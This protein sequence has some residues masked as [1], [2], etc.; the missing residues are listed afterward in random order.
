MTKISVNDLPKVAFAFVRQQIIPKV[1]DGPVQ[2][3]LGLGNNYLISLMTEKCFN[4]L[5][6]K[7]LPV[8]KTLGIIDDK[9][10][11]DLDLLHKSAVS[12]IEDCTDQRVKIPL[13]DN[14]AF[15]LDKSDI[16]TLYQIATRYAM[17]TQNETI[18]TT[19]NEGNL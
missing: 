4:T 16:E 8:M 12:A 2:F 15:N 17:E 18:S 3:L 6:A 5:F 9:M 1:G 19:R 7:Y 10:M 13:F 14:K 11:I